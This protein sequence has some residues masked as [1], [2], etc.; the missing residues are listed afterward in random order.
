[1]ASTAFRVGDR[2]QVRGFSRS[3]ATI[4]RIHNGR[5]GSVSLDRAVGGSTLWNAVDLIH[6]RRKKGK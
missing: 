2:V 3:V 1:M 5:K 6:A 4:C